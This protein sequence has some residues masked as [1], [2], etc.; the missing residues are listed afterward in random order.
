MSSWVPAAL[1]PLDESLVARYQS[2]KALVE[3][4]RGLPGWAG[5]QALEHAGRGCD[6]LLGW[7]SLLIIKMN[8]H[9]PVLRHEGQRDACTRI[10]LS[11]DN[12]QQLA[13]ALA[14]CQESGRYY[15]FYRQHPLSAVGAGSFLSFSPSRVPVLASH[16]KLSPSQVSQAR[17]R[18]AG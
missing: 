16:S 6:L 17:A 3:F 11:H 4:G 8:S 12:V 10:S 7:K 14:V 15:S 9:P 2:I 1:H 5:A 18:Q 13:Q